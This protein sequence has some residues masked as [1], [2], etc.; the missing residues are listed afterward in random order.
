MDG[1][2]AMSLVNSGFV[3]RINESRS[4]LFRQQLMKN[5]SKA[6]DKFLESDRFIIILR[7]CV[8]LR[9]GLTKFFVYFLTKRFTMVSFPSY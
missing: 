1:S 3:L 4:F 6:G 5:H 9:I 7:Y 2:C 8:C